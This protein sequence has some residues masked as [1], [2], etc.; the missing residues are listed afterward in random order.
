MISFKYLDIHCVGF[1]LYPCPRP[2]E[3]EEWVGLAG[4]IGQGRPLSSPQG[5]SD[6]ASLQC[7][8]QMYP[9][10]NLLMGN[11]MAGNLTLSG[12]ITHAFTFSLRKSAFKKC[13]LKIHLQKYEMNNSQGYL[14]WHYT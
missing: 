1:P 8:L 2:L 9:K 14:L 4:G 10:K 12:R 3:C 13:I 5:Y 7:H 11:K 6:P